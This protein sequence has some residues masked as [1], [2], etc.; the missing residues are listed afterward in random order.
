MK[1]YTED[2]VVGFGVIDLEDLREYLNGWDDAIIW[3]NGERCYNAKY[4]DIYINR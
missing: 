3:V 1:Y 2:E 4:V